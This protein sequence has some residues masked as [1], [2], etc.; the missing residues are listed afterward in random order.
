MNLLRE[1]VQGAG[2]LEGFG[3]HPGTDYLIMLAVMG[4]L[5]GA[6]G[7]AFGALVGAIVMLAF[8]G[9]IWCIGCVNRARE[10]QEREKGRLK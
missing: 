4:A 2:Y 6:N 9:P 5:A 1:I 7:G 3:D 8:I 10:Y